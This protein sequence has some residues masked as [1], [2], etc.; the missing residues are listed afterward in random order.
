MSE[1]PEGGLVCFSLLCQRRVRVLVPGSATWRIARGAGFGGGF[2]RRSIRLWSGERWG[3]DCSVRRC[4]IG[5][6]SRRS[7]FGRTG[8]FRTRLRRLPFRRRRFL[9]LG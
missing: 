1:V 8:G 7:G 9:V 5:G 2:R 4:R 3:R 6:R